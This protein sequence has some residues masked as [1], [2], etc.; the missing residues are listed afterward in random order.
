[1]N[2]GKK[3]EELEESIKNSDD[4]E[5]KVDKLAVMTCMIANNDLHSI[6][7]HLKKLWI[8]IIIVLLA[9]LFQDQL[10]LQ[11]IFAFLVK[12]L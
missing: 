6:Y 9:V 12:I 8:G 5:D 2:N 4:V 11:A 7:R 1:M 3:Y 10:S